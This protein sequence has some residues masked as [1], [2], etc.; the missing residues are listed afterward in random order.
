[1][2]KLKV[3][4]NQRY[5][6]WEDGSPFYYLADTGW[7]AA[8]KLTKADI[9][10][11]L[12]TRAKQGFHVIQICAL[13]ENDGIRTPNAYGDYPFILD[14]AFPSLLIPDERNQARNYWLHLDYVIHQAEKLGLII[15]LLPTWGDKF[16]KE[17]HGL[18]PEIFTP[19]N[20]YQYG[21]W[22][23][24][25]YC[26]T[27]NL[28][29]VLGG[30]RALRTPRHT[31]IIDCMATGI[32]C[33]DSNHLM[34]FH[35]CGATSSVDFLRERPYIDFHSIQSG[36]GLEC[37][38]SWNM[39]KETLNAEHK[40]CVDMECRYEDFPACF[41]L[42][43]GYRWDDADVRQNVY[44]NMMEGACGHTYGHQSVWKF[45]TEP[46]EE[47]PFTWK[48]ALERSGAKQMRYAAKLRL[49]RPF[50]EFQNAAEL[51]EDYDG[52]DAHIGAGRGEA[53]ALVYTPL[54][55]PITVHLAKLGRTPIK[56]SWFNPRNGESNVI[57][58]V[59]AKTQLFVPPDSGKGHDWILI[60][61]CVRE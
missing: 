54:G 7:T 20:A 28:I 23:G 56:I 24:K 17:I 49:S 33:Q 29:W 57:G 10:L 32:R 14:S 12:Q 55:L 31:Q 6:M 22:L 52:M 11:Y 34:T 45:Q 35:P 25:R 1:M 26:H 5:F 48:Q 60:A 39:I 38:N 2:K 9:D 53:Y 8:H 41:R 13:S 46:N 30:D 15:A 3:H 47:Y 42:D 19:E 61:D 44:W 4:P 21:K 43:Y 16:N 18:G 51:V 37:Y 58:I 50:F 36:H 27:S 40:P 59:E